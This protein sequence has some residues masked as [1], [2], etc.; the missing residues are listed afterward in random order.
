[1]NILEITDMILKMESDMEEE[2]NIFA[3]PRAHARDL[4]LAVKEARDVILYALDEQC[5]TEDTLDVFLAK[6]SMWDD[7]WCPSKSQMKRIAIQKRGKV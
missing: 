7:K 2:R 6:A 3:M 5:R 4:A 1:M